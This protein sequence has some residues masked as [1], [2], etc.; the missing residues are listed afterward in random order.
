M[1]NLAAE[2]PACWEHVPFPKD[3]IVKDT[4]RLVNVG[5]IIVHWSVCG[6]WIFIRLCTTFL[7]LLCH[8]SD[9]RYTA[10]TTNQRELRSTFTFTLITLSHN[11][12]IIHTC[13]YVPA[14]PPLFDYFFR[15]VLYSLSRSAVSSGSSAVIVP[16]SSF[17]SGVENNCNRGGTLAPVQVV[18]PR[19]YGGAGGVRPVSDPTEVIKGKDGCGADF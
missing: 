13:I 16:T 2:K 3:P 19:L 18:M 11:P 4:G 12:Y 9:R 10:S 6:L 8:V 17:R 7:T 5:Q 1:S 14:L 15:S